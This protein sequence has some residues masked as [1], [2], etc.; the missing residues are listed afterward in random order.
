MYINKKVVDQ[1]G[2]LTVD[3]ED[4]LNAMNPAVLKELDQ[5]IK[6]YISEQEVGVIIITG[7]GDKAF[8]A[9]ADIKLMQ[10]LDTKGGLEFGRLGQEVTMTIEDSPKPVLAAVNGFALGGG[11]E[12]AMACHVRYASENAKFGQP[13][14][15]LGLIPAW[16]GT[17]RLP[18][19]VGKGNATEL[20]IG[21]HMINA[22][23]ALRIG[24]VNKVFPQENLMD[25]TVD[26]AKTILNNGPD[27]L[28]ESLRCINDAAG[29]SL[30]DGLNIEVE[31]FSELFGTDE[32]KEGL[33]AFVE[34]R[35]PRFRS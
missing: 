16:G 3:R 27:C 35:R 29:H 4:A 30:I 5:S 15:K 18:R 23:E 9:G 8:I 21:G 6:E 14:V 1:I 2:I 10:N 12:I 26:F 34:K 28:A 11:C 32:T 33:S 24:L 7:V 31:A 19:I 17:Q 20:I 22:D 25:E 13:E